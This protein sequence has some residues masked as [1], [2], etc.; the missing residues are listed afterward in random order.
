M[1]DARIQRLDE[2][3]SLLTDAGNRWGPHL[4]AVVAVQLAAKAKGLPTFCDDALEAL[5]RECEE[6]FCVTR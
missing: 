4:V 3:E 2:L 1:D 5:E 6:W